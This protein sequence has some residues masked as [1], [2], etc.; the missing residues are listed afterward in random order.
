MTETINIAPR[1]RRALLLQLD[2]GNFPNLA[3][4]R[5]SSHFKALGS[6]VFFRRAYSQASIEPHF[7]DSFDG[8]FASTIFERTS[9][10]IA[11]VQRNFPHCMI[12][13]TGSGSDVTLE[14]IGVTTDEYDY[15]LY[16]KYP[17]SIGFSQRGCRLKCSF[18]VVPKK[19]GKVR[20]ADSIA[21]IW[22]G[23][24]WPKNIL[25][26][27][28]D[29]FGQP[30]WRDRIREIQDGKFKVSFNQGIN[31]RL[32]NQEAAEAIASVRYSDDDFTRRCVYTAWDNRED[33]D[34]LFRGLNYLV[35]AGIKPDNIMVYMLIGYWPG[36]THDDREY[37]RRRLRDFGCRPY[38]MAFYATEELRGFQR[39]VIRRIDLNWTWEEFK[40]A[41][42]R[43]E[44]LGRSTGMPLLEEVA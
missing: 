38:P 8:V 34:K 15:S 21:K 2:G 6:E 32:I 44:K 40:A 9:P 43:P 31:V 25:L 24:P 26:L 12:G 35:K 41:G 13:G 7:G 18:C 16:P 19:E 28:N 17:H 27:D 30:R 11:C 29:F 42:Y 10:L 5:L 3:L 4:M 1:P 22:R 33:E 23:D 37:R 36:E 20:E 39:W 14:Q